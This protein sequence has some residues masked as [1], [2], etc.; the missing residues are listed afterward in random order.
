MY[1]AKAIPSPDALSILIYS[2]FPRNDVERL[3][4]SYISIFSFTG[5]HGR[6]NAINTLLK[7]LNV[8]LPLVDIVSGY[9]A[10]PQASNINYVTFRENYAVGYY[11]TMVTGDFGD[12]WDGKQAQKAVQVPVPTLSSTP[13]VFR[14]LYPHQYYQ[15]VL[16]APFFYQDDRRTYFVTTAPA[17]E[18]VQLPKNANFARPD[19]NL[20]AHVPFANATPID[21]GAIPPRFDRDAAAPEVATGLPTSIAMTSASKA[22]TAAEPS[23][24][25]AAASLL[26]ASAQAIGQPQPSMMDWSMQGVASRLYWPLPTEWQWVTRKIYDLK[27]ATH[28]HPYVCEFIKSLNKDGIP[29]LLTVASQMQS[30]S[31][32]TFANN[33][34]PNTQRVELPYPVEAVDLG[35]EGKSAYSL[36]NWELFFHTVMLIATR[37]TQNQKLVPLHLRSYRQ[38]TTRSPS[39]LLQQR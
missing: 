12:V 21:I 38:W 19:R 28:F 20:L 27:F 6:V 22:L 17:E 24:S 4:H 23:S 29:G 18:T 1:A 8:N 39:G 5:C 10:T 30:E 36:Y 14:I 33:Y 9:L 31:I 11:L 7:P 35:P 2:P 26:T 16:Q 32:P 3:P 37:L 13:S 15:Y 34:K 25:L